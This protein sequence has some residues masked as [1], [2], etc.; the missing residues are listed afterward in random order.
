MLNGLG[1]SCGLAE[2][3]LKRVEFLL[4][5]LPLNRDIDSIG[6]RGTG[7]GWFNPSFSAN[8]GA[9]GGR[10][11]MFYVL[12]VLHVLSIARVLRIATYYVLA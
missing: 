5:Y 4:R 10:K 7:G 12:H 1:S 11:A 3:C 2:P 9:K 6:L 8:S